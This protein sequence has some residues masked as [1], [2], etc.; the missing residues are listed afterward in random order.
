MAP[1]VAVATVAWVSLG[2][3]RARSIS[4]ES[5]TEQTVVG[6]LQRELRHAKV[7]LNLL[8]T[9]DE[10]EARQELSEIMLVVE[11]DFTV[12]TTFDELTER[13]SAARA[14]KSWRAAQIIATGWLSATS[15]RPDFSSLDDFHELMDAAS[16]ELY[17]LDTS[18]RQE[19]ASEVA[20]YAEEIRPTSGLSFSRWAWRSC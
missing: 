11:R 17:S 9:I 8:A 10:Q 15:A 3:V 2:R 13:Q 18:S 7:E 1:C 14:A 19:L 16:R 20:G 12:A 4:D 6:E 5:A